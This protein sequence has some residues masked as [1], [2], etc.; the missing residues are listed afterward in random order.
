MYFQDLLESQYWETKVQK[1]MCLLLY[2]LVWDG[3]VTD[4]LLGCYWLA[5]HVSLM[6]ERQYLRITTVLI[7]MYFD[8]FWHLQPTLTNYAMSVSR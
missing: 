5:S 7:I 3:I 1:V 4:L 6:F 8:G 2:L